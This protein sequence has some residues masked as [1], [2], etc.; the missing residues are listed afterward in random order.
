[1]ANGLQMTLQECYPE[2]FRMQM[3]TVLDFLAKVSALQ[4]TEE[5]SKIQEE[6]FSL[7][8]C[9]LLKKNTLKYYSEKMLQD[10]LTTEK[11]EPL[12]HSSMRWQMWGTMRNGKCLTADISECHRIEQESS[13][14]DI[15]EGGS[16]QIFPLVK[17]CSEADE[18]Q[19]HESL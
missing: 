11:E 8:S 15:I 3:S 17:E 2:M 6:L 16:R 5:D 19:G 9:G 4:E 7:K 13:L 12:E 14:S 18:L 10:F 1:M